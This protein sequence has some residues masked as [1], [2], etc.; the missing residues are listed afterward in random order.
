MCKDM[1][2]DAVGDV[3]TTNPSCDYTVN[4]YPARA[5]GQDTQ[6]GARHRETAEMRVGSCWVRKGGS[7]SLLLA[8][9][10]GKNESEVKL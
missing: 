3:D 6:C 2:R 1:M 7:T 10:N 8:D 5:G 4:L 9:D